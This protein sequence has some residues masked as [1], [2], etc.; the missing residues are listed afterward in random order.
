MVR[1][2][3]FS[4]QLLEAATN[5]PFPEHEGPDGRIYFE[6]KPSVDFLVSI[7]V[8]NTTAS[9]PGVVSE[10]L[11]DGKEFVLST[12]EH[13]HLMPTINIGGLSLLK[14]YHHCLSLSRVR[15]PAL[16]FLEVS[17]YSGMAEHQSV[18]QWD[19]AKQLL[20]IIHARY[21][22]H[23]GLVHYHVIRNSSGGWSGPGLFIDDSSDDEN[24]TH[25]DGNVD[26]TMDDDILLDDEDSNNH[27]EN[28]NITGDHGS[29]FDLTLPSYPHYVTT[30]KRSVQYNPDGL[31][32]T[33][34]HCVLI[35]LTYSDL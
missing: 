12:P 9:S 33:E 3:N 4:V 17:F 29:Y 19:E 21:A 26:V 18:A 31:L 20:G 8:K 7:T 5:L 10:V 2:G 34:E 27:G 24:N 30:F 6:V 16:R 13:T 23:S 15:R 35:D 32:V 22:T 14:D 11:L 28:D 25:D 1:L